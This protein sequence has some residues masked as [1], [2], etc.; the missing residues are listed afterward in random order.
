M[1]SLEAADRPLE[2]SSRLKFLLVAHALLPFGW[3]ATHQFH[4]IFVGVMFSITVYQYGLMGLW[5]GV[6]P[7]PLGARLAGALFFNFYILCVSFLSITIPAGHSPRSGSDLVEIAALFGLSISSVCVVPYLILNAWLTLIKVENP[8]QLDRQYVSSLGIRHL[9]GITFCYGVVVAATGALKGGVN[10]PIPVAFAIL[11]GPLI[12]GLV[13]L[14]WAVLT[15]R[16]GWIKLSIAIMANGFAA[17]LMIVRFDVPPQLTLFALPGIS[18]FIA[19]LLVL[20]SDGYRLV[21]RSTVH[22]LVDAEESADPFE[23]AGMSPGGA[24]VVEKEI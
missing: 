24:S 17:L 3:A 19:S 20:R 21:R 15:P 2:F 11:L 10:P 22:T 6:G 9:F 8:S 5:T 23:T 14:T 13:A 16:F 18:A 4:D 7:W 12:T 1:D